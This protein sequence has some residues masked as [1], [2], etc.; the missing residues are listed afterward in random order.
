MT[1]RAPTDWPVAGRL[2]G[3]PLG[4]RTSQAHRLPHRP[5]TSL[6]TSGYARAATFRRPLLF[7]LAPKDPARVLGPYPQDQQW[8]I[9]QIDAK[10][11][12]K[13]HMADSKQAAKRLIAKLRADMDART[14]EDTLEL[15]TAARLR[16]GGRDS[17]HDRRSSGPGSAPARAGAGPGAQ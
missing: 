5:G 10:G 15:W 3:V 4:T 17:G 9:I 1:R 12:R 11:R 2:L 6:G 7:L 8:R 16:G 13:S 14:V